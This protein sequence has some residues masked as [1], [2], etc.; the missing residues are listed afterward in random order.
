LKGLAPRS[1]SDA[2]TV[3]I[4]IPREGVESF[5]VYMNSLREYVEHVLVIPREGVESW[6][7]NAFLSLSTSRSSDPERGS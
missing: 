2:V 6:V 3:E 5:D 7:S 1:M 4:V